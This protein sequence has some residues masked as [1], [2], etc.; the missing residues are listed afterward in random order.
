MAFGLDFAWS[1]P[2]ITAILNG[3]YTFV[4]RYLSY[5][6]TGK[7]L[8]LSEANGYK[9]AGLGVASNWEYSASAALNGYSQ[10]VADAKE[11]LAQ[12]NAVGGA[13][14]RPIYFSVDW[15][16]TDA[17]KPVVGNYFRGVAS[18]IG[19]A[20]TGAYGGYH[21]IKYLLDNHLITWAWQTYAW[22][23]GL[24]DTR[25]HIR[26]IQNGITV[27]T[28]TNGC[29]RN[30]SMVA[31]FGQWNATQG[32]LSVADVNTILGQLGEL[33][34]VVD[35]ENNMNGGFPLELFLK[36]LS[37]KVDSLAGA[38]K[39]VNDK[40]DSAPAVN[41]DASDLATALANNQAFV[42]AV[43]SA[44]A[45]QVLAAEKAQWAK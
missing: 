19:L 1:K 36:G 20:R 9:S 22:S 15:D 44:V 40:V 12:H 43:A 13:A 34:T 26:Q 38:V 29:D 41:V 35:K 33:R 30:Q 21:V 17:Q 42:N 45:G 14:G 37:T 2:S 18:V 3:G 11:A 10:G 23:G 8:T 31:D 16:V 7:N 24:W 4:L 6:N 25:A 39:A 27:G 32:G 5:D 28:A